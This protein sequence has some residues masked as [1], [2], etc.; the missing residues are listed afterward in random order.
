MWTERMGWHWMTPYWEGG[1]LQ[2][3]EKWCTN[4]YPNMQPMAWMPCPPKPTD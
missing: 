4:T 1:E 2:P 3:E